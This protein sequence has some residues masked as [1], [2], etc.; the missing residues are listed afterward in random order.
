VIVEQISKWKLHFKG[1]W[2][3]KVF[4]FFNQIDENTL[5]GEYPVIGTDIFCK[6]L[7]YDTKDSDWITESHLEY[8]DIQIIIKG[9]E[10]INIFPSGLLDVKNP[11]DS[12]IDCIFY[13]LP[14]FRPL[15][16]I[17]LTP[18]IMGVFYPQDAHT[19]QIAPN[20]LPQNIRKVVFKVH[21]RFF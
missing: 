2:V 21:Q 1:D 11:Y 9:E 3:D 12:S 10:Q 6:I 19:T 16:S 20:G 17:Y 5:D 14:E 15:T 18:G 13:N 8:T 4:D 7:T